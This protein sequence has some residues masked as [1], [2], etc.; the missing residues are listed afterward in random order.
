MGGEIFIYWDIKFLR[1]MCW[2]SGWRF[3]LAWFARV[4]SVGIGVRLKLSPY[5]K[6]EVIL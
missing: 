5:N 1:E 4:C 3:W 2:F 6:G